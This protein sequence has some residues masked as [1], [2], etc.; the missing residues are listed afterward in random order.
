MPR[1]FGPEA[2]AAA[3]TAYT[4]AVVR[5]MET[6]YQ[7]TETLAPT[8]VGLLYGAYAA[9]MAA[10][11]WAA[12]RQ[13]WPLPLPRRPAQLAGAALAITGAAVAAAGVTRFGSGAQISGVEPGSVVTTGLYRHT[14]NPQYLGLVAVFAGVAVA[15]RSGLAGALAVS[16]WAVFNRWIPS[17]ECHLE[18]V[19]GEEYR[20]YAAQTP[21]WF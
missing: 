5:R 3:T 2:A 10:F 15:T 19:F 12:R 9:H 21:R 20:A 11:T 16:A 17:E 14:R 18:R 4:A 1:S 13:R 8:T 6:E 7:E